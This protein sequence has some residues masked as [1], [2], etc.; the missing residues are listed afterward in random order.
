MLEN[1][2][3]NA[4]NLLSSTILSGENFFRFFNLQFNFGLSLF[5]VLCEIMIESF[6][7]LK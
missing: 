7:Y 1:I 3:E 4:F 6:L 5:K 2:Q